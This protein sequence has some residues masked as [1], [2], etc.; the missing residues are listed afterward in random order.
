MERLET[1]R[2]VGHRPAADDLPG[3][4][5]VVQDPRVAATLWPG[6]LGGPRSAVQ[7]RELLER[8][9]SHWEEHGFG[10]WIFAARDGGDPVGYAGP[11]WTEVE[12]HAEVEITYAIASARWGQGFATEMARAAV[13]HAGRADLVCFTLETNIASQRVMQKAGFRYERDFER[14]GRPH[15]L[16][17]LGWER[18]WA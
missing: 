7:T 2:L 3:L 18:G 12:S 11:Q 9:I 5:L 8:F 1:Q 16:Y 10:P 4:A 6:K 15:V 14:A 17:R 13:A